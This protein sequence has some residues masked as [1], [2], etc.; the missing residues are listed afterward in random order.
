MKTLARIL[1]FFYI[2]ILN[3]QDVSAQKNTCPNDDRNC[4]LGFC[5]IT[6]CLKCD[7]YNAICTSSNANEVIPR[8]LNPG[9]KYMVITYAGPPVQIDSSVF[10]KF[11][12]LKKLTMIGQNITAL[13]SGTFLN[14]P[15]LEYVN[16]THSS[17]SQLPLGLFAL[18]NHI[19]SL[20]FSYGRFRHFPVNIFPNIPRIH[21]MDFSYNPLE[22]CQYNKIS[23]DKEFQNLTRLSIL[24]INGF[25]TSHE[26]CQDISSDYLQPISHIQE[27][28]LSESNI[29][30]AGPSIL[31]PLKSLQNLV[32]D[33][34]P[35][36]KNCPSQAS[37][38]FENLPRITAVYWA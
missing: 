13:S 26:D 30:S 36:F 25:G 22:N 15:N 34:L 18:N 33:R 23:I 28:N 1:F 27:I 10:S 21:S 24:K 20:I 14:K 6:G 38:L 17:I 31:S 16:F 12:N 37:Q 8:Q 35:L 19:T 7:Q 32:I 2:F 3:T 11:Y 29:F 4:Q 5:D 9:I